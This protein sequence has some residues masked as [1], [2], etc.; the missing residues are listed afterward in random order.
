MMVGPTSFRQSGRYRIT[1]WLTKINRQHGR[2]P[3]ISITCH[4][5]IQ[6]LVDSGND[7]AVPH[8]VATARGSQ[9]IV[10]HDDSNLIDI[11]RLGAAR[12]RAGAGEFDR[13][14]G[15]VRPSHEPVF[16]AAILPTKDPNDEAALIDVP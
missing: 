6:E 13:R 12:D 4:S 2:H 3:P 9:L 8:G 14:R 11:E 10:A 1:R 16:T 7:E 5:T 15:P